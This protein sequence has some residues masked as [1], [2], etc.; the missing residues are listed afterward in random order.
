MSDLQHL[1]G[2]GH[3]GCEVHYL[4]TVGAE[5]TRTVI[6]V[7]DAPGCARG[8]RGGAFDPKTAAFFGHGDALDATMGPVPLRRRREG[9]PF[10]IDF[11]SS[12]TEKLALIVD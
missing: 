1:R 11:A 7:A 4:N 8:D 2:R 3:G 5:T 6:A 9:C 12:K 10:A